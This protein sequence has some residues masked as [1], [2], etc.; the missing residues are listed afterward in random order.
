MHLWVILRS[1]AEDERTENSSIIRL[2]QVSTYLNCIVH[3]LQTNAH[4]LQS[5]TLYVR[6]S[7]MILAQSWDKVAPLGAN[8][9]RSGNFFYI[10]ES[11]SLK[12]SFLALRGLLFYSAFSS[13]MIHWCHK[14]GGTQAEIG[15]FC[16]WAN[17]FLWD[18]KDITNIF[19]LVDYEM[20]KKAWYLRNPKISFVVYFGLLAI[21]KTQ[22][23]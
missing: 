1:S 20:L 18:W 23:C 5:C 22:L 19:S 8:L 14:M 17:V 7:T 15:V 12:K 6:N 13:G 3:T 9:H 10:T 11:L 2:H 21:W 16:F 4:F